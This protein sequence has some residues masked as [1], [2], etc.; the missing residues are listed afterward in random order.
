MRPVAWALLLGSITACRSSTTSTA[1]LPASAASASAEP[2][3]RALSRDSVQQMP[4]SLQRERDRLMNQVLQSI[5]GREQLPA[6]SVFKDIRVWRG[7]PAGRLPRIMNLGWARSLGVGCGHCHV[8]GE[9]ERDDSTTK[10]IARDMHEMVAAINTQ[11]LARVPNLRS[12]RPTVN[13][14]TCH[15]GQVKP[16]LNLQ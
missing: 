6:E 14:T 15:R 4:D 11:L 5:R 2:T 10:E 13:C 1:S 9:W 16:A 7:L 12:E 8:V 3:A